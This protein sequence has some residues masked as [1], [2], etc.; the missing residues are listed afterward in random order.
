MI[1]IEFDN[2]KLE[3]PSEW[4]DIRLADYEQWFNTRPGNKM[5]YV[6]FV[7]DICGI[8]ADLL[9]DSPTQ[10]FE[11]INENIQFVFDNDTAPSN[12]VN[13]G[14]TNYYIT[15]SDKL[16]LGEWVDVETTLESDSTT[17]ISEILAI[18]CRPLSEE[19]NADIIAARKE[20]FRNLSCDKALPLIAFF[21]FKKRESEAILSH[22]STVLTQADLFLK[23]IKHF[24]ENGDGTKRLPIW[25][26]IRYTYLTRSLEKQLSKYSDFFS[27]E[28][29]SREPKMSSTS[30]INR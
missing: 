14:G 7:A 1:K 18:V 8:D 24:V 2:K 4:K 10:L 12:M 3:I 17:K 22:F 13:I 26:R 20:V 19:Y 30:L 27:T 5:E 25:Q 23:G 21:L 15:P 28:T 6:R 11:V 9:L 29:T 16:T